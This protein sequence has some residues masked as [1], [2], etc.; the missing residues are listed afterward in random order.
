MANSFYNH[1]ANPASLSSGSSAIIRAEFDSVTAGFDKFPSL[2]TPNRALVINSGGTAV[3]VTVG[4]FALAGNFT[5]TGAFNTTFAQQA[6]TTLT[7]PASSQTLIEGQIVQ[8]SIYGLQMS[9][10]AG[11]TAND[12]TVTAGLATSDETTP[13]NVVL[14]TNSASKTK[15]LDATWVTGTN[16]GGRSSSLTLLNVTYHVFLIRVAGVDDIGFDTSRTGATLIADH[17]ATKVRRIGSILRESGSNVQFTQNGDLFTRNTPIESVS[18]ND[19]GTSGVLAAMHVPTGIKLLAD[20]QPVLIDSS[21]TV[22]KFVYLSAEAFTDNAA[23]ATNA[24]IQTD[25]AQG[26]DS[27]V[28]PFILT[29]TSAQIRYR[30]GG[31]SD[32]DITLKI[33]TRG[34]LD[35]RN[36][37]EI[38]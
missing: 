21:P 5:T 37:Y 1:G 22:A 15:R 38:Q 9:N 13:T 29:N 36:K 34:W 26:E 30:L 31:A 25:T 14:L 11:D 6:T 23:S 2:G 4:T 24:Q 20:V 3:T 16:Q 19:P 17:A 7:L 32:T 35:Q 10:A 8:G 18:A 12:I 28:C 33:N 27:A